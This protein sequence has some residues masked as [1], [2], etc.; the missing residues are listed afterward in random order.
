MKKR[1]LV[2]GPL[3]FDATHIAAILLAIAAVAWP[4]YAG[5]AGPFSFKALLPVLGPALLA[6]FALMKQ[7]P[8]DLFKQLIREI[9]LVTPPAP[10][11]AKAPATG[12][13]VTVTDTEKKS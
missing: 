1:A 13:I 9:G 3:A 8:S 6:V 11:A 10:L 7:S 12:D 5:W 2:V 4:I